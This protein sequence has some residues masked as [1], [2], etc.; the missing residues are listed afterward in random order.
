MNVPRPD[1]ALLVLEDG[2]VG[3]IG[4]VDRRAVALAELAKAQGCAGVVC[5]AADEEHAG[6]IITRKSNAK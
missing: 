4:P 2:R 6:V 5:S 1:R 3:I